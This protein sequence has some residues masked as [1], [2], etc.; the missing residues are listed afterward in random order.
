MITANW[1]EWVSS[2]TWCTGDVGLLPPAPRAL[3]EAFSLAHEQDIDTRRLIDLV[4]QDPV[5]AIRV[6]RLANV[7][8]FAAAGEV[9]SVEIAVV[10]LGTRAVRHAVLAACFSSWAHTVDA[11]GRRGTG[12]IQ[13]AVGTACLARRI[14]RRLDTAGDDAFVHGLLHDVGKLVLLRLRSSYLRLGGRAPT[15]DEFDAVMAARHGDVGAAALEMWGIPESVREPVRWHH[16]PREAGDHA[17]AS[18]LLYLS[19]R[20]SHRY[21]FGRQPARDDA[22]LETDEAIAELRLG[23]G[24]LAELDQ[25]AVSL[26]MAAQHLVS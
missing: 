6:L 22:P 21:G 20:L 14:A 23:A 5:F 9:R 4:S 17:R 7:A 8:A 16:A 1:T 25:E 26:G 12:E 2:R 15:T 19:N 3:G 18:A 11:H 10:R 13:H 24:W